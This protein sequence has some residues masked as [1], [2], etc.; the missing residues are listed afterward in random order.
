MPIGVPKVAY[1]L[2]GEATPHYVRSDWVTM[3][4]GDVTFKDS[5]WYYTIGGTDYYVPQTGVIGAAEL[6][7]SVIIN[8]DIISLGHSDNAGLVVNFHYTDVD[9][10]TIGGYMFNQTPISA[11]AY[12]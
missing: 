8:S 7:N 6:V 10:T 3:N 9:D 5:L 12:S 1:R 2:P 4:D 11:G